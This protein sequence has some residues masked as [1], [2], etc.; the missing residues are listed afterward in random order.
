MTPHEARER[1]VRGWLSRSQKD[2]RS[3]A[4]LLAL[5]SPEVADCLFHLQQAVEKGA[6]AVL[7]AA[8]VPFSSNA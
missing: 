5:D 3:A 1:D 6:K 2:L 7:T 4:A 8:D